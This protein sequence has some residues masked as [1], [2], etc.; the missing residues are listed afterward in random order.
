[1]SETQ[2]AEARALAARVADK[3]QLA[4]ALAERLDKPTL[5]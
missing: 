4:A 5:P 1:M 2:R 3:A